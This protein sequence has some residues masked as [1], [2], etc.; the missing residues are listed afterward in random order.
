MKGRKQIG[1]RGGE[2]G[3]IL[4]LPPGSGKGKKKGKVFPVKMV[5][6]FYLKSG[7]IASA[8]PGPRR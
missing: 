4:S 5:A 6:N 8:F 1:G 2:E 3:K 7:K